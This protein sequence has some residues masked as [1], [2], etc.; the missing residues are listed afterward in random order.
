MRI[1]RAGFFR[2]RAHYPISSKSCPL[3][4]S[5]TRPRPYIHWGGLI[6]CGHSQPLPA[7]SHPPAT[8]PVPTPP[9]PAPAPAAHS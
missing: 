1:T 6:V 2:G 3:S 5:A 7:T 9:V 4:P 8:A